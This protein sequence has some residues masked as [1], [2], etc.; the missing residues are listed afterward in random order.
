[1]EARENGKKLRRTAIR[2]TM[3]KLRRQTTIAQTNNDDGDSSFYQL[4]LSS[5]PFSFLI[6]VYVRSL[7]LFLFCSSF[8]TMNMLDAY[9]L[10]RK[11]NRR[12]N[13]ATIRRTRSGTRGQKACRQHRDRAPLLLLLL[14]LPLTMA[15]FQSTTT[16]RLGTGEVSN[17]VSGRFV[18]TRTRCRRFAV[19]NATA[20]SLDLSAKEKDRRGSMENACRSRRFRSY[21]RTKRL[22][23]RYLG[24]AFT[25]QNIHRWW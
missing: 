6:R 12:Q 13:T 11:R 21:T 10:T 1:M 25:A 17:V 19:T 23:G 2:S 7:L 24:A 4:S 15:K 9:T 3:A 16:V 22:N 18:W 5:F 14:L 20:T 8:L